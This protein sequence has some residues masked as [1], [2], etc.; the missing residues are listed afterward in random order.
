MTEYTIDY[1]K[2]VNRMEIEIEIAC[3]EREYKK[4]LDLG[5]ELREYRRTFGTENI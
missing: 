2:E 4:A 1:I 3:V 5:S